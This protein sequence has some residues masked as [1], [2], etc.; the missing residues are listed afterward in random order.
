MLSAEENSLLCRIVGDAPM[1]RMIRR[2]WIPAALSDEVEA[3]GWPRRVRLMGEDLIVFRDSKG[4][5][6]L[7]EE[8]CPHRGTSLLLARNEECGL[9]CLYHGWKFDV[10][11]NVLDMPAEIDAESVMGRVRALS[12][13]VRESG[14]IVWA[15][16]G[17]KGM[18]PPPLDFEFARFPASHVVHLKARIECNWV[19]SLEGVIDSAHTNYLHSDTFKPA[20]GFLASTYRGDSLLVDRPSND[21]KPRFEIENMPYGFRYAAIRRPVA[22]PEKN[23]YVRV[24]L[25]V[26]PFYGLFAGQEGWGSIQAFVPI[27]DTHTM[28]Y[29][30]RYNLMHPIDAKE[31]ERQIAWTGFLPGE[32]DAEGRKRRTR[33]N[34]W[35]QD[36]AAMREG[37]SMSGIR[38]VQME[39][40]AVQES[41]G[42][43]YDRRKE[44]LGSSDVAVVRMRRLMLQSLRDF[45]DRDKTPLGLDTGVD[46]TKLR[47]EEAVVPMGATWQELCRLGEARSALAKAPNQA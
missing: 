30:T 5:V 12:Y 39:D 14:G 3:D 16:M 32:I 28:L 26:A 45:I 6:G 37:K 46:Y 18:E 9:R 40:A 22:D 20:A 15:Y 38:G 43:L 10:A 42:P 47:G 7:L 33:E 27:D 1:G 41:M 21:G 11:G 17:E 23:S 8:L 2:Y 29:F 25:F 4:R 34:D 19:Q 44:H 35:L 13:P 36:R 24:T 31:R